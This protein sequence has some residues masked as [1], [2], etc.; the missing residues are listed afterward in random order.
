M[1]GGPGNIV[2]S[3]LAADR[4]AYSVNNSKNVAKVYPSPC[5]AGSSINEQLKRLRANFS[6]R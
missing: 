1:R 6:E 5:I 2:R 3:P 4:L